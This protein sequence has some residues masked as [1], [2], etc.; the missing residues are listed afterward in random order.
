MQD[1]AVCVIPPDTAEK[2]RFRTHLAAVINQTA[3]FAPEAFK[4]FTE[5]LVTSASGSSS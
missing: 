3:G 5:G 1:V 4:P 2:A